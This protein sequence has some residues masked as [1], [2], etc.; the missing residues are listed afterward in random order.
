[1]QQKGGRTAS[2]GTLRYSIRGKIYG[3]YWTESYC[4]VIGLV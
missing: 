4:A 3:A 1:M 2:L